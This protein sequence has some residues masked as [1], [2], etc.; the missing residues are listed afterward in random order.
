MKPLPWIFKTS[1]PRPAATALGEKPSITG[2]GL[3]R[4]AVAEP[5]AGPART[6]TTKIREVPEEGS[7]TVRCASPCCA[8]SEPGIIAVSRSGATTA[9]T[10]SLPF[11][12]S[13]L[14]DVKPSPLTRRIRSPD[15]ARREEGV[16]PTMSG[17]CSAAAGAAS[18]QNTA[19][20]HAPRA[21]PLMACVPPPWGRSAWRSRAW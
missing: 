4:R 18:A 19:S 11:Q 20:D 14:E 17:F 15:P 12:R 2:T 1:A 16:T 21:R 8:T 5:E 3:S 13:T 7:K 6:G 9:V 10:R